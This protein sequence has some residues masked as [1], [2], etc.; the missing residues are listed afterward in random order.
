M[1][2]IM[3]GHSLDN[4][5]T[6][7]HFSFWKLMVLVGLSNIDNFLHTVNFVR[8]QFCSGITFYQTESAALGSQCRAAL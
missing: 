5:C 1:L 8:F 2:C 3:A 6:G 4:L 7:A